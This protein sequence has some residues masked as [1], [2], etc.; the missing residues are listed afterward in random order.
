M[1]QDE[2]YSRSPDRTGIDNISIRPLSNLSIID[3]R[4][5]QLAY[6]KKSMKDDYSPKLHHGGKTMDMII[7]GYPKFVA[8]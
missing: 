8:H 7:G 3:N 6:S 5:R 4:M 2:A 1:Y